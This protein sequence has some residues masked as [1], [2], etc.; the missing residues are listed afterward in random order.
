MNKY[1]QSNPEFTTK[2]IMY[3]LTGILPVAVEQ[4]NTDEFFNFLKNQTQNLDPTEIAKY[5]ASFVKENIQ[6]KEDGLTEQKI[7]TPIA[8][9]RSK[10]GDCKSFALLIAAFLTSLGIEN[11]FRFAQYPGNNDYTHVYNYIE[12]FN[13][14]TNENEIH[15]FDACM[16]NLQESKQA[17][18]TKDMKISIIGKTPFAHERN[19]TIDNF[20]AAEKIGSVNTLFA[21][22][23]RI[24]FLGLVR[25]NYRGYTTAMANIIEQGLPYIQNF[26]QQ[27]GGDYSKLLSAINAGK[28]KNPLFGGGNAYDEL[29]LEDVL[30]TMYEF[31]N[32]NELLINASESG[33][34]LPPEI[35]NPINFNNTALVNLVKQLVTNFYAE[36]GRQ[37]EQELE[38][39]GV[40]IVLDKNLPEDIF[41]TPP[42]APRI[43]TGSETALALLGAAIPVIIGLNQ[44]LQQIGVNTTGEIA[45]LDEQGNPVLDEQGNPQTTQ[46]EQTWWQGVLNMFTPSTNNQI[47]GG[48]MPGGN[49]QT[50][51]FNISPLTLIFIGGGLYLLLRKN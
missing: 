33:F 21:A 26:W 49:N 27:F 32:F 38:N 22:P 23:M 7:Q 3:N 44:L 16:N 48:T 36:Q 34:V 24:A 41:I 30:G 37:F 10:E 40:N 15:T 31:Q 9:L 39:S 8:L 46:G 42:R 19:S 12:V 17:T 18:K 2:D 20:Q 5:I 28:N 45:V 11:G 6:Y 29:I 25:L 43:G 50:S 13:P 1:L 4:I 51:S 35:P 47:P 14:I